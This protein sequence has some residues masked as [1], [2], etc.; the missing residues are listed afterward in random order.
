MRCSV[1]ISRI[2]ESPFSFE[3]VVNLIHD[4][5]QER[6]KQ[7]LA[8][9]CSYITVDQF[10]SNTKN[11]IVIVAYDLESHHLLGT[12][13]GHLLSD[14]SNIFYAYIEYL[15]ISEI[16]KRMGLASELLLKM[17]AIM[18]DL[19]AVYMISDTACGAKSSVKWHLKNGF[20]IIALRSYK[21][22]NYYSYLFRKQLMGESEWEN[23]FYRNGRFAL[24]YVK[25]KLKWTKDG[26][27]RRWFS[28]LNKSI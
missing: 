17:Q 8:F 16:A 26:V 25:T 14:S 24:S 27:E 10:V 19:G 18:T 28:L 11:G 4:S 3:D 5:F 1:T 6:L 7:G 13:S 23:C 20:R 15:A 12:L 2:E 21:S 9:T 22:T